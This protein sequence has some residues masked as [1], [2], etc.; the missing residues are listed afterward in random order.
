[1]ITMSP[2]LRKGLV[3]R[4]FDHMTIGKMTCEQTRREPRGPVGSEST[5]GLLP[6]QD[7]DVG[8]DLV[9]MRDRTGRGGRTRRI[10]HWRILK[11][12]HRAINFIALRK[13]S[14]CVAT[15][16]RP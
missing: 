3:Q 15:S 9:V 10:V 14:H 1:M 8:F 13:R 6:G 11:D 2:M 7:R 4:A 5:Y 12:R 16:R